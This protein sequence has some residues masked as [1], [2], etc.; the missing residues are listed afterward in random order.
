MS[1][2]DFA[3]VLFTIAVCACAL[4]VVK[5]WTRRIG[6]P[7]N[8]PSMPRESTERMERM[9]RTIDSVAIEIERI[10]ENQRFLTKLLAERSDA[11]AAGLLPRSGSSRESSP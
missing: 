8:S 5:A 2:A 11:P 1:P 10:S 7:P 9:E 3:G 4:M 6:N